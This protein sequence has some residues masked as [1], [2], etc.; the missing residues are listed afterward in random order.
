MYSEACYVKKQS[1]VTQIMLEKGIKVYFKTNSNVYN[2]EQAE[3]V[4]QF[5]LCP[6]YLPVMG[7]HLRVWHRA[8]HCYKKNPGKSPQIC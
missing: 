4:E 7:K 3:Q 2:M 1:F 5:C 6:F 8:K